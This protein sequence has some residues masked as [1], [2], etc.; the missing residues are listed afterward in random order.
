M[1]NIVKILKRIKQLFKTNPLLSFGFVSVALIVLV[2]N[3]PSA[4]YVYEYQAGSL[5][6][7]TDNP[8]KFNDEEFKLPETINPDGLNLIFLADQYLSWEGFEKDISGLMRELKTIEPWQSYQL[9]NIYQIKPKE[10]GLCYIKVQ[11]ERKPV[12]R[13]RLE[14]NNY[15]NNLPLENFRL[16]VLSRQEF[17]SWANVTRYE[18]SGIFFSAPKALKEESEQRVNALL[19]AH[20][21]GHTFGLKD[22]EIFVLAQAGGAP[23]TPDG[24]N[25]A[26][27]I[28]TAEAWWG[29]SIKE[30]PEVGYFEGCCGNENYIKPTQSSI[31][32][33]NTGAPIVY[34]YGPI[35]EDYLTKVL[36]YCFSPGTYNQ[37]VA[38]QE[39]FQRYPE[40]EECIK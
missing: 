3:L 15:L 27:G 36:T 14:I 30:Y 37:A 38:D 19:L 8:V 26:P 1:R 33:L 11:D 17:Q 34:N 31:M 2:S 20:L 6:Q 13:C 4:S 28:A 16:I 7:L 22:E 18:N 12:L 23:H 25:C 10:T 39:F 35:S 24:P 29:D 21:F 9:F 5:S 32:N 40:F